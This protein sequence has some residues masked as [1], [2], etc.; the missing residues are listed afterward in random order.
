[1]APSSGSANPI[2][3]ASQGLDRA[4][5][6]VYEQAERHVVAKSQASGFDEQEDSGDS[7]EN[8]SSH[9]D[10]SHRLAKFP[11]KFRAKAKAKTKELFHPARENHAPSSLPA[12]PYLAP[13]PSNSTDDDRL[14][15]PLPEHK[16]MQAKDLIRNPISTVQSALHGASGAKFAQVMDNQV[17]AHGANVGLVRAWDKSESAQNKEE[18]NDAID[19]VETL[20]KERQDSYVRWTMDRHV[21]KVRQDPPRTLER[22][23]KEDYRKAD[24]EGKMEV[25]WAS[26]GRQVGYLFTLHTRRPSFFSVSFKNSRSEFHV[27]PR[28]SS[29]G[30]MQSN[31]AISILTNPLNSHL[32]TRKQSTQALNVCS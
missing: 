23:R 30:S 14:Y 13:Y 31:T 32:R 3:T 10:S 19:K 29:F 26:Y 5:F 25:Q 21:L 22:P 15:N 4:A 17:I 20:K 18:K 11:E 1:M 6:N 2:K 7:H 9:T 12:A 27:E 8:A 16:G 28:Y 24:R